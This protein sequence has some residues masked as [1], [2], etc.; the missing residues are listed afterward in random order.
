MEKHSTRRESTVLLSREH[1]PPVQRGI[2]SRRGIVRTPFDVHSYVNL[3]GGPTNTRHNGTRIYWPRFITM[4]RE[5]LAEGLQGLALRKNRVFEW[6][7]TRRMRRK[8]KKIRSLENYGRAGEKKDKKR[9][10]YSFNRSKWQHD[11]DFDECLAMNKMILI[12]L[13]NR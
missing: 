10:D 12:F 13:I 1:G 7:N 11:Y 5:K 3:S 2:F 9:F 6:A 4:K 8:K